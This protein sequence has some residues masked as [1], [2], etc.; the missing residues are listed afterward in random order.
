MKF[1]GRQCRLVKLQRPPPEMRI[2][3]PMR[4]ACSSTSHA[5]AALAG[6]DGAHQASRTAAQDDDIECCRAC[7]EFQVW[8]RQLQASQQAL[9]PIEASEGCAACR[10]RRRRSR[11]RISVA[12]SVSLSSHVAHSLEDRRV[13]LSRGSSDSR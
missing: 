8:P 7:Y 2:F 5:P 3:F 10:V 11:A 9:V 6:F 12:S 13:L 4:S 1:S